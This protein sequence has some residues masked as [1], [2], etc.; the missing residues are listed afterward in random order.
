MAKRVN[1]ILDHFA[2][3]VSKF[4]LTRGWTQERLAHEMGISRN[5]ICMIEG[6]RVPKESVVKLFEALESAPLPRRGERPAATP[7]NPV[8][9]ARQAAGLTIRALAAATHYKIGQ[10]QAVEDDRARVTP[11]MAAA[12]VQAL[13]TLDREA[14]LAPDVL[15]LLSEPGSA[16]AHGGRHPL[17]LGTR[18]VPLITW[19]Q[20]AELTDI[21]YVHRFEGHIA[22]DAEDARAFAVT[23]TGDSMEP[24]FARGDVA[25]VYPGR[26]PANGNLVLGRTREGEVFLKRLT[27]LRAGEFRFSSYN[28]VYPAFDRRGEELV[29]LFPV[30]SVHKATL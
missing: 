18:Y 25:I 19:A 9:A 15:P 24:P 22:F 13:P 12:L 30:A 21:D 6:G 8:R 29:W 14:L 28:A 4:R 2:N 5:Y 16:A 27:I 10:L 11:Q 20:A 26:P 23:I 3:R 1:T 17:G 7:T